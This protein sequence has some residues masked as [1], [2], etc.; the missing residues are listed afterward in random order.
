MSIF[1]TLVLTPHRFP[2]LSHIGLAIFLLDLLF[3]LVI[4]LLI[5]LRFALYAR[6]LRR[7]FTRPSEVL[8]VPTF[9][10]SVAAIFANVDEYARLFLSDEQRGVLGAGFM[11]VMFWGYL[12]VAFAVSVGQYHLLFT[13]KSK[14]RL[15]VSDMTPAWILPISPV[16]L[17]GTLAAV[18]A[19]GLEG[20]GE[21]MAVLCAG[22]AAQGLGFLVSV[23]FYS[24]YLSRLMAFGLPVQ[25]PGM[26]GAVGPPSFTCSAI[27]G[28]AAEAKMGR[29]GVLAGVEG[30]DLQTL[31]TGIRLLA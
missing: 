3:F 25:R 19:R 5:A 9:L 20:A 26:F 13:V 1:V 24:T 2:G 14:R 10:L 23:F 17:A 11:R 15:T 7:T 28:M 27:V 6:T 21:A 31:A 4:T 30:M 18:V 12:A 16:M 29:A 8:F 22:S